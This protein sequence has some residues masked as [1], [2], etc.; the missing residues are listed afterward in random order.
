MNIVQRRINY[1]LLLAMLFSTFLVGCSKSQADT[2]DAINAQK[3]KDDGL[4]TKYL[5][6]NNIKAAVVDSSGV[7]TGIY[8]TADSLGTDSTLY[9][10]STLIT[11]GY[12]CWQLT[13][14]AT[15]GAVVQETNTFNPSFT[16]GS[17]IDGWQLAFE[18]IVVGKMPGPGGAITLYIPSAYA[19]GP[20]PQSTLGL[21][22]NAVLIFHI[23]IYNVQN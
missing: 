5:A 17:V 19:Y 20:Y 2:Q 11:V 18:D 12:T 13:A 4:I 3:I 15:K 1:I 16:L 8:Y 21:P 10:S 14:N 7:S 22:A 6:A 23:I 9:T